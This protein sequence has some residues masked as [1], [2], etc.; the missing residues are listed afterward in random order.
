MCHQSLSLA[1]LCSHSFPFTSHV[2]LSPVS[3]QPIHACARTHTHTPTYV[4]VCLCNHILLSLS[5]PSPSHSLTLSLSSSLPK[6]SRYSKLSC[7]SF[8]ATT[9]T[10]ISS[11]LLWNCAGYSW[12]TPHPHMY[13]HTPSLPLKKVGGKKKKLLLQGKRKA[14]LASARQGVSR[15]LSF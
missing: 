10:T 14:V 13:K 4:P 12:I 6:V 2:R 7:I 1:S 11:F 9:F 15:L 3:L 8:T 5:L